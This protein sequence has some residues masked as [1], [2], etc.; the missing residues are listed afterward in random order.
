MNNHQGQPIDREQVLENA[1][2]AE[3]KYWNEDLANCD[4]RDQADCALRRLA[5]IRTALN[6]PLPKELS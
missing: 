6:A 1:L 2:L 4:N 3:I 5:A